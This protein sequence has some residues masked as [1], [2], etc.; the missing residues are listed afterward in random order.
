MTGLAMTRAT[1]L[2]FNKLNFSR[3]DFEEMVNK[4][5]DTLSTYKRDYILQDAS[6]K[7]QM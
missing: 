7:H 2:Q 1:P 3:V 4:I 6:Q 5:A